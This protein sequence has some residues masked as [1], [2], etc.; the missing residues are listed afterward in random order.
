MK[1]LD[2]MYYKRPVIASSFP[3]FASIITHGSDGFLVPNDVGEI[4]FSIMKL[5]NNPVLKRTIGEAGHATVMDRFSDHQARE[6]YKA[7]LL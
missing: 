7:V 1:V 4:T 2:Y 5:K 3:V 6:A